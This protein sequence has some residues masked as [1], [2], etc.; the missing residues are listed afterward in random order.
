MNSL[1]PTEH[2]YP[3]GFNYYPDFLTHDEESGFIDA[4]KKPSFIL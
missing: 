4:I 2:L 3:Q 1:F